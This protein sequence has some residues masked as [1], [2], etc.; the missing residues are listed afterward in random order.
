MHILWILWFCYFPLLNRLVWII[1]DL[2]FILLA[3]WC[4]YELLFH[5]NWILRLWLGTFCI[6]ICGSGKVI[7]CFRASGF[8]SI[9]EYWFLI[10]CILCLRTIKICGN[11]VS[12]ILNQSI[13]CAYWGIS[14][15]FLSRLKT[16]YTYTYLKLAIFM[17]I[18]ES[19]RSYVFLFVLFTLRIDTFKTFMLT[20]FWWFCI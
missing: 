4:F 8:S 6:S 7:S 3:S 13:R 10:D 12:L 11:R 18:F 20:H 5:I 14:A 9:D 17:F 1:N 19:V 16:L 15:M 2:L